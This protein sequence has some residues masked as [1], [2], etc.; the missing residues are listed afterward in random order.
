MKTTI[1]INN[2]KKLT[3]TACVTLVLATAGHTQPTPEVYTGEVKTSLDRLEKFMNATEQAVKFVAPAVNEVADVSN[4][5][6]GLELLAE[7][8]EEALKYSAPAVYDEN[9][10]F[11]AAEV[12]PEM[13]RL[14]MLAASTEEFLK[15]KAPEVNELSESDYILTNSTGILL[16]NETGRQMK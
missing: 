11:V 6:K 16:A 8:T 3:V 5:M 14:E 4:E 1:N 2:L 13:E 12:S 9:E 15:Y 7:T 10:A